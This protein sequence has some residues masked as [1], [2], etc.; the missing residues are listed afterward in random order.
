MVCAIFQQPRIT[1][2]LFLLYH[3]LIH[4]ARTHLNF[5]SGLAASRAQ[6]QDP[7]A[8]AKI[9][10]RNSGSLGVWE[11]P[12]R[13]VRDMGRWRPTNIN[14]GISGV[15]EFADAG[16]SPGPARAWA[17]CTWPPALRHRRSLN[18]VWGVWPPQKGLR[19]SSRG[20]K[21]GYKLEH[22]V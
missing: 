6:L 4:N 19:T 12:A 17:R 10:W 7:Q 21:P 9:K 18:G 8:A 1:L 16:A 3:K 20:R 14:G 11:R 13:P 15:W 22:R 2:F 5:L